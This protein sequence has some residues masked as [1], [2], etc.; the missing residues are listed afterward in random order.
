MLLSVNL[1]EVY[2]AEFPSTH[3]SP[4]REAEDGKEMFGPSPD[5]TTTSVRDALLLCI[6][7]QILPGLLVTSG[8]CQAPYRDI[9]VRVYVWNVCPFNIR[10]DW[11]SS[12]VLFVWTSMLSL[13][14]Y[15]ALTV[16]NSEDRPGEK[17]RRG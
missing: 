15:G 1:S 13:L 5:T 16:D 6:S 3:R 8:R 10:A 17:Q 2:K 14:C 12:V 11:P 7:Q 4:P 9:L